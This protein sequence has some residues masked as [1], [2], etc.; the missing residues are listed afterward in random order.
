M[1]LWGKIK[2][3][4]KV[5]KE[6][7]KVIKHG[8]N[9]NYECMSGFQYSAFCTL[10]YVQ[11]KFKATFVKCNNNAQKNLTNDFFKEMNNGPTCFTPCSSETDSTCA[12][13]VK[14]Y[15]PERN[16]INEECCS[17]ETGICITLCERKKNQKLVGYDPAIY[18][19]FSHIFSKGWPTIGAKQYYTIFWKFKCAQM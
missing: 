14:D 2:W 18:E 15:Q 10:M 12:D 5:C 16:Y 6:Y 13:S 3:K 17:G 1:H 19:I 11:T 7:T 8:L 9:L 4:K